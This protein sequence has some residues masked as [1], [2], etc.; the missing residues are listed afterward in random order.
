MNDRKQQILQVAIGLIADGGYANLT[1]RSLARANNI[2][3]G[4]LQYHFATIADMLRGLAAYIEEMYRRSFESYRSTTRAPNVRE[5]IGFLLDDP[6]K[7][8]FNSDRLWPQLWAMSQVEPVMKE[9]LDDIY[10]NYLNI[11]EDAIARAGSPSPRPE[12]LALM[13][14]IEG[15]TLFVGKDAR[16][17]S[18]DDTVIEAVMEFIN[19]KYGEPREYKSFT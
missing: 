14:F 7:D 17:A 11:I 3:L 6:P 9:L 2:T 16:W 8:S 15:S 13:S 4:A 5:V 1:M 18:E 10:T 12:A 19:I